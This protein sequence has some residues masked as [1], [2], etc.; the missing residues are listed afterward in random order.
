MTQDHS[1]YDFPISEAFAIAR[2]L[3]VGDT[4]EIQKRDYSLL[5]LGPCP[6]L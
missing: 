3:Y 2:D 6:L 4:L 1:L 5:N